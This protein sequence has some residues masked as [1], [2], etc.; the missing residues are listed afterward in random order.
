MTRLLTWTPALYSLFILLSFSLSAQQ[1][2]LEKPANPS[3][4]SADFVG[5]QVCV[6]CHQQ[7]VADWQGSHHDMAM[8]HA[9]EDFVLGNFD[10]GS[11]TSKGKINRFY[12]KG[13]QYWVN[14]QGPDGN[15]KDYKISYTLGWEPLQQYMIEFEDGRVQLIPF[16]WDSRT[17]AQGGQRWFNLYPDMTPTDEF[18]W[19]N[20]GQNWNFMCA[21]CHSTNLKK[22]YNADTNTYSTTFSEINVGCEACHGSANQH[23]TLAAKAEESNSTFEKVAHF[24]FDRDLSKAVSEWSGEQNR[25]I[26]QPKQINKT[27]QLQ[28]CA[29]C[30]SRRAQLN[31][32]ADHVK[33]SFFDKYRLSLIT[34]E[35]YYDDGKIYD[36][37]YVYGSFLQSTMAEKGLTCTNCHDPHSAKL[38]MP[39]ESLCLQCHVA[40]EYTADKHTFHAADSEASLC[41]TCHM[42]ETTYMEIDP[43]RDHSWHVPRPDL[44]QHIG[45]PNVCTSC[46]KDKDAKWAS[47]QLAQWF[48]QSKYRN[49]QHFSVAF[50]AD[51]IG[52]KEAANALA[53]SSQNVALKDIIRGSALHRMGGKNN[54]NTT[55]ALARAVKSDS[56][57]IRIGAIE[58]SSGY[59]FADRWNILIALLSD[60]VLAVRTETAVALV[61]HYA[62]M[63]P[64]QKALLQPALDE[65]IDIQKFNS[66]RGFGRTNLANVYLS[67]GETSKAIEQYQQAI[68]I[69]PNYEVSY[70]NL[71][72][73]YRSLDKEDRAF[74]VLKVGMAAQPNSSSIAFSAG[75]SLLR[76]GQNKAAQ[77]YL[78]QAAEIG[79]TIAHYWYVYGL[80]LEKDNLMAA[81]KALNHAFEVSGN[82]QHKYAQCE[83]L[84]RNY[85]KGAV[86]F[87]FEQC[88]N[89]LGEFVPQQ[90]VQQLKSIID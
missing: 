30:H 83:I 50:Y 49:S 41:V 6:T 89:Q 12:R 39:V 43:R 4:L 77:G 7:Q 40:S 78:K 9:T 35:L 45:T 62:E 65:Y 29:Q 38:I 21:D 81:S 59:E 90:T 79:K 64:K 82:S 8:K 31:D 60:P 13:E 24:G 2:N 14:I 36:E 5:S 19:T 84:A 75:L 71:A 17:K 1:I 76:Q 28:T 3:Q 63:S 15:W 61:S 67:L 11:L 80:S 53:Y 87:A 68:E 23:I 25:R 10:N 55:V 85:Q 16:A 34:P 46:H 33:G 74:T 52:H 32:T 73:L 22:N 44:S 48:P 20:T 18:Y 66:D 37:V 70:V 42:P 88:I 47:E 51:S 86:A 72:D 56:V 54:K 57:M 26:L 58:G 69:E 27:D